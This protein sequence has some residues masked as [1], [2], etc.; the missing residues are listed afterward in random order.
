VAGVN[1]PNRLNPDNWQEE[2]SWKPGSIGRPIPGTRF[3]IVDPDSFEELPTGTA[4]MILISGAQVMPHYLKNEAQTRKVLREIAGRRWYV[5]GDKGYLDP[6]GFLFIQDRYS[7]FAKISGEMVG[8]GTVESALRKVLGDNEVE[9]VVVSVPDEKKGEKLVTLAT[10]ALDPAA[11]RENLLASGLNPLA[12]PALY[13][14]VSAIPKLGS[15]KTDFA[16]ARQLALELLAGQ[17]G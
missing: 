1:L 8:L 11:L 7:R 5:T 10:A 4:G 2:T 14:P 17:S 13:L 15:G 9:V 3:R 12:L 16:A 6:D